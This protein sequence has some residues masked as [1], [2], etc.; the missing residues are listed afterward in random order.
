MPS[1]PITIGELTD[2]PAFDSPIASPWAQEASRR[3]VH[4]FATTAERDAKYPAATAGTGAVC[5]VAAVVY[6]SDGTRWVGGHYG[7]S[8]TWLN[9]IPIGQGTWYQ[10]AGWTNPTQDGM[11]LNTVTGSIDLTVPLG[12]TF[13]YAWWVNCSVA[14]T[15]FVGA[16][17]VFVPA[18]GGV[19][20]MYTVGAASNY[21][22]CSG[23]MRV[24]AGG[25]TFQ[26]YAYLSESAARTGLT[27]RL[28]LHRTGP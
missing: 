11:T 1:P 9:T 8:A 2:V 4:R 17:C 7:I 23:V 10:L 5:E 13:Q 18:G 22:W 16:R 19:V 27:G 20:E 6:V 24:P 26:T 25:G 15:N 14:M 28:E 3:I 12:G 21:V